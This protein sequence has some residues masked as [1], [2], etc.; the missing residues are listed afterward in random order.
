MASSMMS[1]A[2]GDIRKDFPGYSSEMYIMSKSCPFTLGRLLMISHIRIRPWFRSR[3]IS[4]GTM[5]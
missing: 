3:P 2:I 4:M 5:L 1:A